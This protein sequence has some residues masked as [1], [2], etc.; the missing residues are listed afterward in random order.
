MLYSSVRSAAAVTTPGSGRGSSSLISSRRN[1]FKNLKRTVVVKQRGGGGGNYNYDWTLTTPPPGSQ[2]VEPPP[3]KNDYYG[4]VSYGVP[5]PPPTTPPT[6]APAPPQ[7]APLASKTTDYDDEKLHEEVGPR[8]WVLPGFPG[9]KDASKTREKLHTKDPGLNMS[10]ISSGT[11]V[12]QVF[13]HADWERHR[14]INR[15][16]RVVY[17]I[18]QSTV[19][20][21][22][23]PPVCIP[24]II[25]AVCVYMKWPV[26]AINAM[27][28][29]IA[30]QVISLMLVF[31]TNSSYQRFVE[32][33]LHWG[34]MLNTT[35]DLGRVAATCARNGGNPES[36]ALALRVC[37]L[38]ESFAWLLKAHLRA[39]LPY[40]DD[41]E[42]NVVEAM[43]PCSDADSEDVKFLT[44]GAHGPLN[45]LILLTDA[46]WKLKDSSNAPF[47]VSSELHKF[48][49]TL[50]GVMGA[51]ER[52][53]KT[54]IPLSYTRHAGRT[55]MMFLCLLPLTLAPAMGWTLVPA[56]FILSYLLLGVD[57][58]GVE[59]EEPFA[60]LPLTP[61]CESVKSG[62]KTCRE[63]FGYK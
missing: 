6:Q 8:N 52:L 17:K 28:F 3:M 21:R 18:W 22:V 50:C 1:H 59:I 45:C 56:I 60:I 39:G 2:H 19:F 47:E 42:P 51:C 31:R 13:S 15:Y 63:T 41:V 7:A 29:T 40:H 54:P 16:F 49:Q 24:T 58:I 55:L 5:P 14:E 27:P 37:C 38:T 57:E 20:R 32:C 44:K 43:A 26:A 48:L 12:T 23:F 33:R 46:C 53:L 36:A 62:Q 9:K 4:D 10:L 35:R 61:I 11:P 25:A 34:S 30:G